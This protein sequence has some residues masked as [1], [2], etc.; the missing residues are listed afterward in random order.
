MKMYYAPSQMKRLPKD[1]TVTYYADFWSPAANA[2]DGI[3][4][5]MDVPGYDHSKSILLHTYR[6]LDGSIYYKPMAVF[7][8][9]IEA[10]DFIILSETMFPTAVL[11]IHPVR[12]NYSGEYG[13]E[14]DIPLEDLSDLQDFGLDTDDPFESQ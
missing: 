9:G 11:P 14:E 6:T 4:I 1:S 3:S 2:Y 5:A 10:I 7:E 12:D 8:G 13:E